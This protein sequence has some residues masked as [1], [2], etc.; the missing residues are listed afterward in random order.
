M[1]TPEEP[2]SRSPW[3]WV[4]AALAVVCVGLLIW[5]LASR[6]DLDSAH[7]ELD[8][9]QQELAGTQKELDSA[10]Q[11]LESA[12]P[13]PTSTPE[14]TATPED[15]QTGRRAVLA[16]GA[17]AALKSVYDDLAEQLGATQED[18]A[19]A[20]EDIEAANKKAE[21]ADEDAAAAEKKAAE[22]GDE[23]DKAKA[24]ADQA[25]AEA[26]AAKSR[27]TVVKDCSKAYISALG[28][29]FDGD[30]VR[31]QASAVRDQFKRITADCK[32]ALGGA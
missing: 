2:R 28:T 1:A 30:D 3:L 18:L 8:S 16:G 24:E 14:P 13:E 17:V 29:L 27:A 10:Q 15:D 12:Q 9:T 4:S 19:A 26:E 25:K 22:A 11:D 6:S 23:T 32:T 31:D 5:A 7:Q 21:A 20:E